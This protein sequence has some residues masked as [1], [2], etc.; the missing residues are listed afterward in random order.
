MKAVSLAALTVLVTICAISS[1]TLGWAVQFVVVVS[2]Y[3]IS[4]SLIRRRLDPR[5]AWIW[6]AV[7]VA[8]WLLI[9][10][11]HVFSNSLSHVY[12]IALAPLV[13]VG[14]A[15]AMHGVSP[16]RTTVAVVTLSTLFSF[17]LGQ[18]LTHESQPT[19]SSQQDR[20]HISDHVQLIDGE[21]EPERTVF[22][23]WTTD[24]LPCYETL[25]KLDRYARDLRSELGLSLYPLL[26][27]RSDLDLEKAERFFSER[28]IALPQAVTTIPQ[29]AFQS[30]VGFT[31][32]PIT[33][34]TD[35]NAEVLYVGRPQYRRG[36]VREN[37]MDVLKEVYAPPLAIREA[38]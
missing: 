33:I 13:A 38:E 27:L 24:C 20:I 6:A 5:P 8:P 9:Y 30:T 34:A 1:G 19:R 29:Q 36:A 31:G 21:L 4:A 12:H 37:V 14:L 35:A 11:S 7:L 26:I 10:A 3:F 18:D 25:P 23:A 17:T 32:V 2:A 15:F 22:Y 28:D 16:V